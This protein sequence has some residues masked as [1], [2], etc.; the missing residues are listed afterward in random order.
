[1]QSIKQEEKIKLL[2]ITIDQNL[3]WSDQINNLMKSSYS[4]LRALKRFERFTP[5]R[6]RKTLA[7]TLILSKLNY[8][9]AIYADIP[10]YMM[11]RLQRIQIC[12]A[13]FVLRKFAKIE[14]VLNL[15]WLPMEEQISFTISKYA[16]QALHCSKWPSYLPVN[17]VERSRQLRSD[18]NGCTLV[19]GE[20]NTFQG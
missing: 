7:E 11:K 9:N 3:S 17:I 13:G 2:G 4:T 18:E 12:T 20:P 5:F 19:T 15:N 14:D 16:H 1:M 8:C 6:V 10:K